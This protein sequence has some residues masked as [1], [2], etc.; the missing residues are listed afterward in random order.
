MTIRTETEGTVGWIIIDRPDQRN[1][2]TTAMWDDIPRA[3]ATLDAD[4]SVRVIILR[5]AGDDVFAAGADIRE[6]HRM[7]DDPKALADFEEKFEAAQASLENCSKPVIAAIQGPC[8]GGGLALALACDMRLASQDAAFAI[9][10]ARLGLGY[11]A[12]AVARL[13]RA[14]GPSNAFDVLVTARRLDAETACR[15]GLVNEQLPASDVFDHAR[16][17]AAQISRNAPLTM[18]AAKA[19][20]TAL[21]RQDGSLQ[22]AE[23]L[24]MRCGSSAD[25]AEGRK[26]FT[27]NRQPQFQGK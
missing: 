7:G 12:P 9:P 10:A 13:L 14:I 5:G 18:Q 26:A 15:M 27:E 24:I 21:N 23:E 2:L 11:A 4:D 1:A 25:F 17:T 20:I 6:L 19:T 22:A 16:K 3:V 8:M